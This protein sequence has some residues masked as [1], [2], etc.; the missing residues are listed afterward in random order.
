MR[1]THPALLSR[2]GLLALGLALPGPAAA[3]DLVRNGRF[4]TDVTG[5]VSYDANLV[6]SWSPLDASGSAHSGSLLLTNQAPNGL[7]S[8]G[9]QC[10]DTVTPG[11]KLAAGGKV[12]I[13]SGGAMG[14]T[15]LIVFFQARTGCQGSIVGNSFMA[16]ANGFD[17]WTGLSIPDVVVPAGAASARIQLS[18]IKN[19]PNVLSYQSYFDDLYLSASAP[20]TLTIPASASIHG[21]NYFQT[22]LWLMNLSRTSSLTVSARHR[23]FLSQSCNGQARTIQLAPRQARLYTDVLADGLFGDPESSGAIELTYDSAVATLAATSRTYTPPLPAPTAGSVLPAVAATEARTAALFLGLAHNGG[24]RSSG[25]RSNAGVYNPQSTSVAVTFTLLGADGATLGSTTHT[26][27][28]NE[29]YQVSDVFGAVGAGATVTTNAVLS[30]TSAAP[31][32]PYVTVVD[33]QSGD[34]SYPLPVTDPAP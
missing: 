13:P 10:I 17:T 32:F 5:W 6:P 14:Q 2:A 15:L 29:P 12:R 27:A 19:L 20:A 25:F 11:T 8:G 31:V 26:C 28:P 30:V 22:D 33:N 1:R 3:Q 23:C 16:F 34:T 21:L 9:Q 18:V 24:D 4:D 7:N